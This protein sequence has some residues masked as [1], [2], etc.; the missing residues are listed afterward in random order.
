MVFVLKRSPFKKVGGGR[1]AGKKTK[2]K[3]ESLYRRGTGAGEDK[4]QS[5]LR[6]KKNKD[7]ATLM[8]TCPSIK[9]KSTDGRGN[10]PRNQQMCLLED[11][12]T[13]VTLYCSA[14]DRQV[15]E[16]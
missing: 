3:R 13:C 15:D 4:Y 5:G 12:D 6:V 7:T 10:L 11:L 16:P 1:D 2:L 8:Y 9:P 14:H